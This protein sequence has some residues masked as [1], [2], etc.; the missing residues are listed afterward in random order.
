MLNCL[1]VSILHTVRYGSYFLFIACVFTVHQPDNR[2]PDWH[3][4]GILTNLQQ[5]VRYLLQPVR[6]GFRNGS[7]KILFE[8]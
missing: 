6:L 7:G 2:G 4:P 5:D 8:F 3:L 1:S